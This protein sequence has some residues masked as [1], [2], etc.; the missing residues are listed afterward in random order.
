MSR[1]DI[2]GRAA[3]A[4]IAA[5][6]AVPTAAGAFPYPGT[7][8]ETAPPDPV[9]GGVQ[10]GLQIG[11]PHLLDLPISPGGQAWG[12]VGSM[13]SHARNGSLQVYSDTLFLLG[14][15]SVHALPRLDLGMQIAGSVLFRSN[16]VGYSYAGIH[17]LTFT[18]QLRAHMGRLDERRVSLAGSNGG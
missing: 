3:L 8:A 11:A 4:M 16:F 12:W 15:W 1:L 9:G 7:W 14:G 2:A 13:Y 17:T 6:L 5:L 18:F 10:A